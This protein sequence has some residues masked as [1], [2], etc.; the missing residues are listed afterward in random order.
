MKK[1]IVLIPHY[2]NEEA[3]VRSLL[4]IKEDD[5]VDVLVVDD[6]SLNPPKLE[7]LTSIYNQGHI[8]LEVLQKNQ[9]IE[10]A[11]NHG[12]RFILNKKYKFT[13][14]LD[15]GDLNKPNKY[16][17]QLTYLSKHPEVKLLGTWADM[18]SEDGT[19]LFLLKHPIEHDQIQK[20]MNYNSCFVH[21]SVVFD[22]EVLETVGLYPLDYPAAEDFAFFFKIVNLFKFPNLPMQLL[23]YK[24]IKNPIF[25]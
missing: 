8:F 23:V 25:P 16:K 14:R 22:N 12:L 2:N 20:K 4:S 10:R 9:G 19:F 5:V 3:L 7:Q 21:P 18:V 13:A 11:L 17:K 24:I 15:C 6:G 1:L